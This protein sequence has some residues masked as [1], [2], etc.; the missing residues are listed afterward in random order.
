[1]NKRNYELKVKTTP[2]DI[3]YNYS[4]QQPTCIK[5]IHKVGV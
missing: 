1:M 5:Q 4:K 2:T 3:K